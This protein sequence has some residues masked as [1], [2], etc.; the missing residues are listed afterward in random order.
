MSAWIEVDREAEAEALRQALLASGR[1][2]AEE[3]AALVELEECL[4]AAARERLE[5]GKERRGA[6]G[7]AGALAL[8]ASSAGGVKAALSAAFLLSGAAALLF[9]TLWFRLAGLAL[10]NG[11]WASSAVLASF[12]AGLA[13]GNA[14]AAR[15]GERVARPLRLYAALELG[16]A[17]AGVGLVLAFPSLAEALAPVLARVREPAW[18]L[19]AARIAVAFVAMLLPAAAMGTTLPLL[20]AALTRQG[21][22]FGVALGQLYGWNTA[23]GVLGAVS[24]EAL[25]IPALGLHGAALVAAAMNAGAG[26]I[27][28]ALDR[29]AQALALPAPAEAARRSA[30]LGSRALRLLGAAA[31]AGALMLGLEVIWLRFLQLFVFGTQL[32]FALMLAVILAGIALGGLA[33]AAWQRRAAASGGA[34][35]VA[36]AA[37]AATLAGYFALEPARVPAW[38]AER[39][40]LF[41]LALAL[42][43]MLLPS[44]ASGLLFVLVGAAL[45]EEGQAPARAAGWLTLANTAGAAVGA[46]L[47]GLLLLPGL[48]VER[49]LY[50]LALAYGGVAWLL[51]PWRPRRPWALPAAA[52]LFA[53]LAASF[54]FGLMQGR[55]LRLVIGGYLAGGSR[56][57]GWREAQTETS[58]LLQV[59]WGGQPLHQRLVTNGHSMTDSSFYG[60]RYMKLFAYWALA[61]RPESRRAL[62]ISY[63]VGN[64]AEALTRAAALERIDVVDTSRAVLELS[65]LVARPGWGE[66]LD[67]PRVRV[68]VEDGRFHLLAGGSLYDVVTAEPP[69]P[70]GAGIVNLYTRE[71]FGLVRR[72]LVP[73]GIATHWLPVNQLPVNDTRA[74]ARAFCDVF[75]DCTLW[76]GA[77][78]DWMLAGTNGAD[79]APSEEAFTRLWRQPGTRE[80][81]A[82]LAIEEPGQLGA[83]FLADAPRLAAWCAGAAPLTDDHPGRLSLRLPTLADARAYRGLVAA[84]S[85]A[86]FDASA[87][88]RRVW[89]AAVRERT[90]QW[91]GDRRACSTATRTTPAGPRRSPRPGTCSRER[92]CGACRCCC[93]AASR[94]CATSRASTRA[95]RRRGRCSRTSSPSPRSP[96]ATTPERSGC[97]PPRRR[98][99]ARC[100]RPSCCAPW[101]SGSAGAAPRVSRWPRRQPRGRCPSTPGPGGNR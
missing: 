2:A 93:W 99:E 15:A 91:F 11:V 41:V 90:G 42:P 59:D 78:Y 6:E 30:P 61:L 56:V 69:P 57:L 53:L 85:A 31:L 80:D 5:G 44:L 22:R 9:E 82:D 14:A 83:L 8:L 26:A 87:F 73:G 68:H 76:S 100:T 23:G 71:Y 36:L 33:A 46:P 37:G 60:R 98:A 81:I 70:R 50:A 35:L 89:P 38:A 32:A 79:A 34:P 49:S 21:E 67:D 62:L 17:V 12:M 72:R 48:G 95:R 1:A 88:V 28:L 43:L 51:A 25:L 10:G 74:I 92:R 19:A 84:R 75:E 24:A 39:E 40:P 20:A 66:P 101:R 13:L 45:R 29:R 18:A 47:A 55:F 64:T 3:Q 58:T 27:A 94:G 52:A 54:P 4:E 77:G 16:V 65:R 63:G 97:S 86:E 7:A 96:S